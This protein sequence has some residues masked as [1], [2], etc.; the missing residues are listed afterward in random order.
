MP[1]LRIIGQAFWLIAGNAFTLFRLTWLPLVVMIAAQVMIGQTLARMAGGTTTAALEAS[2]A[3]A[4][5]FYLSAVLQVI[6]L[7]VAA[8]RVHELVLFDE[9][10]PGQYFAFPFGRTEAWYVVMVVALVGLTAAAGAAFAA[11]AGVLHDAGVPVVAKPV[12]GNDDLA[13]AL[14]TAAIFAPLTWAL[15]WLVA[16]IGLWPPAV[17]ANRGFALLDAWRVTRG[18]GLSVY[19]LI[20]AAA[21]IVGFAIFVRAFAADPRKTFEL[22]DQLGEEPRMLFWR[23][24]PI[25]TT[26]FPSLQRYAV[27]PGPEQL[28]LDFALT[29]FVLTYMAAVTSY[30]YLA[31]TREEPSLSFGPSA[32]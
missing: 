17:V 32:V 2:P 3:W 4:P 18:L 9:R 19:L 20:L 14:F 1:A 29:F 23:I 31:L 27:I 15:L 21:Q 25:A 12:S 11:L 22:L 13:P 7:S 16:R 26:V 30:A 24:D 5:A 6:A 10:R 28:A 8:V